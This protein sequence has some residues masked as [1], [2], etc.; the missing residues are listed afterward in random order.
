LRIDAVRSDHSY[1]AELA[2]EHLA[3]RGHERVAL[4]CR[5]SATAPW[6][7]RGHARAVERCGLASDAPVAVAPSPRWGDG[8]TTS[9]V[10]RRF[11]ADCR[12]TGT[13]AALVL[14]HELAIRPLGF[15][16]AA[17]PR[18]PADFAIVAPD[19]QTAPPGGLALTAPAPP[20]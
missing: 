8:S 14:P 17:G 16:E 9:D 5:E 13:R 3:D 15:P 2:V 19:H 18:V 1:G 6:I 20:H 10:L 12:A 4:L 7:R 11:L